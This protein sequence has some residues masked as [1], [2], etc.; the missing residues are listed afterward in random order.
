MSDTSQHGMRPYAIVVGLDTMQG[1]QTARILARHRIP[2]IAVARDSRHHACRTRVCDKILQADTTGRELIAMLLELGPTLPGKAVVYPCHDQC[3][4]LISEAREQLAEWYHIVMADVGV[5]ETLMNKQRFY[6]LAEANGV[7]VPQTRLLES[8]ADAENAASELCFP[9]VIKPVQRTSRW[10]E[11]TM[12]KAFRVESAS[13]F[14]ALYDQVCRWT[15]ALVAQQWI[16]GT[17][18]DLYSCNCYFSRSS[19]LVASFI[20]RKLRQWPPET[21]SSCL[22]EE[23]R[24]DAVLADSLRI[25]ESVNYVGLGYMEMKRDART[26]KHYAIEA[27][28][29]RP[30]GRS[31]IA[32]A[33]GVDMLYAM[34][35]DALGLPLPTGLEQ[36]YLGVKWIDLRHDIQSALHYYRRG[37]LTLGAWYRSWRGRKAFAV[38]S[39]SDPLPF[40]ADVWRAFLVLLSRDERKKRDHPLNAGLTPS[41]PTRVDSGK[42][43]RK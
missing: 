7:L 30:T 31:A 22:G 12:A 42:E 2:V 40:W 26:G 4:A 3:V 19:K 21:G 6:A 34:Y 32:E 39:W 10:D 16:E 18:A 1:L 36:R 41:G 27:N 15:P 28:V 20:A 37:Q 5:M 43:A 23:C 11:M 13:E 9:C 25:F 29:G 14:L 38:F 8:R 24:N 17:D 35:C 33:G